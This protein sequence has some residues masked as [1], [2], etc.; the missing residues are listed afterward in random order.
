MNRDGV[1]VSDG[2]EEVIHKPAL[3]GRIAEVDILASRTVGV[4]FGAG[5]D[6]DASRWS[7]ER[8]SHLGWFPGWRLRE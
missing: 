1:S 6:M 8:L 4:T 3:I 5:D 2:P 7:G